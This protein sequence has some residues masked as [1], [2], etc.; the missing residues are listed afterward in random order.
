MTHPQPS[1][2][3]AM[4]RA[5][6][7]VFADGSLCYLDTGA[8]AQKPQCVIDTVHQ[9]TAQ[10]YANVHRGFYPMGG[11]ITQAFENARDTVARF[12]NA[13][14]D[15]I[16]FTS[17]A[18]AGMNTVAHS[19]GAMLSAGDRV[20]TTVMEH[21][22]NMVPWQMLRDTRGIDLHY[23]PVLPDGS[24]DMETFHSLLTPNT[25]LVAVTHV[26]NVLGTVNPVKDIVKL[27]HQNNTRV[28]VDGSQA[29]QHMPVDVV[30]LDCDF[31]VFT[32]HKLYAPTGVGVLYGKADILA[33]MPP[34]MGGGDMIKS[35]TLDKTIYANAP[36]KF[37]S[38]T[39][40]ITQAIAL[41]TAV[42]YVQGLGV[43]NI[44]THENAVGQYMHD[45]LNTIA[46]LTLYGTTA[47]KAP[48]A[49]F[50][51]NGVHPMDLATLLGEHNVCV[52][53]GHH[54][55]EPLMHHLGVS[56]TVRASLGLYNTRNDVDTFMTTLT[57]AIT[58]LT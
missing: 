30:D 20:I 45:C 37:E 25:K 4:V 50:S 55:A 7:P 46:G 15:G 56:G 52:R 36:H 48:V 35:V 49:S 21:H 24:L 57:K 23:V 51:V 58:M 22:A 5:D 34:F 17:N 12:I 2:D 14:R 27:C 26:S 1:L 33:E 13:P 42:D 19:L 16:I 54:C 32:G 44:A 29:V 9:Y 28:L 10:T 11:A 6:F 40:P 8:S 3:M 47:N 43:A 53:A 31:Y 39:P 38:G 18:T 41:A